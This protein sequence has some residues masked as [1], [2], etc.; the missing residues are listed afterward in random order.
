MAKQKGFQRPLGMHD[1]LPKD[2]HLW[3]HFR[4]VA[5]DIASFYGFGRIDTPILEFS[6]LFEKGTG[7][8][9]DIVQKEMFSLKTRGGDRLTLRPEG[10]PP[11]VR[12]YIQHGMEKL[13]S[14]VKLYYVGP[15]FRHEKP[16]RGRF[17]QL[18]QFGLEIIGEDEPARDVQTIQTFFIILEKL[19]IKNVC[20][21]INTI[22]CNSCRPKYKRALKDYYR[23]RIKN[24]CADCRNRYRSNV[25]RML[26]CDDE[27]CQRVKITAPQILDHLCNSC[28]EHFKKVLELLDYLEIP[29]MLN[30]YLVRGL[31]YY[32]RTVFEIFEGEVSEGSY[33][34][35][36]GKKKLALASGGRFDNLVKILGGQ[37]TPAVGGAM[38]IERVLAIVKQQGKEISA[39]H[40]PQVFLV[41]LGDLAKKKALVLFED[42]RRAGIPLRESFGRD[43]ISS[44]LKVANKLGI[45][46]TIIIG[47]KEVLDKVAIIREMNTGVQETVLEERLINEIKKRLKKKAR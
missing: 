14:P 28:R 15:M 26:D 4:K 18:H 7:T 16:Q 30:P 35:E 24:V 40:A 10:T 5:E 34:T 11:A 45:D 32:T 17:R 46:L 13:P 2:Q 27:K 12:A 21:E 25:L 31:D 19:K 41:Q 44:Q 20:L 1:I 38:G 47:Q 33:D 39:P 6:E 22:G 29:Y 3:T 8:D 9:T 43:S 23:H 42:F 36:T 37:D